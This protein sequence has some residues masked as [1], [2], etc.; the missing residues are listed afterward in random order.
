M[1]KTNDFSDLQAELDG[2]KVSIVRERTNVLLSAKL[3]VQIKEC[4]PNQSLGSVLEEASLMKLRADGH[5][6]S[7][8]T[9][10][11]SGGAHA[12]FNQA[13]VADRSDSYVESVFVGG[14]TPT[15]KILKE[16]DKKSKKP[17]K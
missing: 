10:S 9:K 6:T 11:P 8:I 17:K 13:P 3:K 1:E 2:Q 5:L 4:Y 7:S 15:G 12:Y 14:D 16:Q